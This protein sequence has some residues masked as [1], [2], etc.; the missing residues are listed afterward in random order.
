[1]R[2]LTS[3]AELELQ[4]MFALV[5][6]VQLTYTVEDSIYSVLS[7]GDVRIKHFDHFYPTNRT[8]TIPSLGA[9][10]ARAHYYGYISPSYVHGNAS[11]YQELVRDRALKW[12]VQYLMYNMVDHWTFV[13]IE[14]NPNVF[15]DYSTD[16]VANVTWLCSGY[17][18]VAGGNGLSSNVRYLDGDT[19]RPFFVGETGPGATTYITETAE[20]C[21]PRCTRVFVFQSEIQSTGTRPSLYD[22]N[23]TISNVSNRHIPEHDL[24]DMQARIAAGAIGLEGFQH[25]NTTRQWVRYHS[26]FV[27]ALPPPKRYKKKNQTTIWLQTGTLAQTLML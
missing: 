14:E 18:V 16:R 11:H 24:P 15:S 5:A 4:S 17:D 21:G 25:A 22:C 2:N 7:Q 12:G 23:I 10:Q 20:V 26:K 19:I 6:S 27:L 1:M 9:E 3:V 8:D 13:F